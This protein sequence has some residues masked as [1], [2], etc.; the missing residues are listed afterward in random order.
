MDLNHFIKYPYVNE[1]GEGCKAIVRKMGLYVQCNRT[2]KTNGEYCKTCG[3]SFNIININERIVG[4][5]KDKTPKLF[6]KTQCYRQTLKKHGLNI[7]KI[8]KEALKYNLTLNMNFINEVNKKQTKQ[9]KKKEHIDVSV[10][11]D[12]SDEETEIR[13]R[14]RPKKIN[15]KDESDLINDLI[16]N[17]P[18]ET[19]SSDIDDYSEEESEAYPFDYTGEQDE[20]KNKSLYI[21]EFNRIYNN[22]CILIG[23]YNKQR[24]EIINRF[25]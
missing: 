9:R 17:E 6:D 24:N 13:G 1:I 25:P 2:C 19:T 18:D 23:T 12:T 4:G 11:N 16:E 20:Y 3:F 8:K 22:Q 10:V 15:D 5:F 14:G 21:D 7:T